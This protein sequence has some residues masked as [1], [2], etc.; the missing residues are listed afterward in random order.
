MYSN[1]LKLNNTLEFNINNPN[2][3]IIGYY[4]SNNKIWYNAWSITS[5]KKIANYKK[6]K[7]LLLYGLDIDIHLQKMNYNELHIYI[8]KYVLI[9]SKLYIDDGKIQIEFIL[10]II[11]FFI[12]ARKYGI[13][14]KNNVSIF[15]IELN[16]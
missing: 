16:N 8:I 15:F 5:K 4:T 3:H 2:Q 7:E 12:K 14:K 9:N 11:L 1:F 10:S 6:S 13:Y